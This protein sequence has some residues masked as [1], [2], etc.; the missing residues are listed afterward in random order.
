MWNTRDSSGASV[1]MVGI[2]SMAAIVAVVAVAVELTTAIAA[3]AMTANVSMA[4]MGAVTATAVLG[5]NRTAFYLFHDSPLEFPGETL[6]VHNRPSTFFCITELIVNY[7]T[8]L[9][10]QVQ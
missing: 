7:K 2:A 8:C 5:A 9:F 6:Q 4:A 3:T 1:Q 10:T